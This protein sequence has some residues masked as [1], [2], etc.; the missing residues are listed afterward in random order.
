MSAVPA[1]VRPIVSGKWSGGGRVV[2]NNLR[3]AANLFPD[4]LSFES[5]AAV[6]LQLRNAVPP[7]LLRSGRFLYMPQ[8]AWVW[9]GPYGRPSEALRK[10]ALRAA[11]DMA[12]RRTAGLI[13]ISEAI[14][15]PSGSG[16]PILHNVLDGEFES[17]LQEAKSIETDAH[18]AI[19]C[20]GSL[21]TYRNVGRLLQAFDEY[22]H[23]GGRLRLV[24]Q[25][26][27]TKRLA[28]SIRRAAE[29]RPFLTINPAPLPRPHVLAMFRDCRI[30]VFPALVEASSVTL[31]EALATAQHVIASDIP[32][33]RGVSSGLLDADCFFDPTDV[34][35]MA[36]A[37]TQA[38]HNWP[39]GQPAQI[40]TATAREE[41]RAKWSGTLVSLCEM[42]LS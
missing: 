14:P 10:I 3:Y 32:G 22:R 2:L 29:S 6:P 42:L 5:S 25:G 30:A 11:S 35:G 20:L 4:Q 40:A 8:N 21:G 41:R 33:N 27:A 24:V 36:E 37:L 12:L 15:D 1:L 9:N 39:L 16:L 13:R 26:P 38:E 19:V 7:D 17:D 28:Q 23:R 31:L 18:D 34:T